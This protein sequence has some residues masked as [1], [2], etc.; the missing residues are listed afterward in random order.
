MQIKED[1]RWCSQRLEHACH[2]P[3][4]R[5]T[6]LT[7]VLA[8]IYFSLNSLF[9]FTNDDVAFIPPPFSAVSYIHPQRYIGRASLLLF[10]FA[11]VAGVS[12]T[13]CVHPLDV[14]RVN[15]Q[16]DAGKYRNALVRRSM[17]DFILVLAHAQPRV[18]SVLFTLK[19]IS[20]P[21][22]L[23][24]WLTALLVC[25]QHCVTDIAKTSGVQRGLYAGISAGIFRQ[26]VYGMPRMAFYSILL[27]KYKVPGETMPFYKKLALGLTAGGTASFIGTPS[28]VCLV[29]MSADGLK[30][31]HLRRNYKHVLDAVL[32][33][34][35]EE[36]IAALW[37]GAGPTVARACLL[38]AGQLGVY[39]EA[40]QT[41][42]SSAG[43][44]GIPLM[45]CSSIVA[46]FAAVGLSCPADVLKS[47]IQNSAPGE[48]KGLLDCA[49]QM[50]KS[51][52]ALS[53]WKGAGPAWIKLTPHTIISFIVLEKITM[54][55]SGEAAM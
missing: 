9:L 14:V 39:S 23:L 30:P 48:F 21:Y 3:C 27:E 36:G 26:V 7:A 37:K 17:D 46:G 29:R 33:I 42:E 34:G 45:F 52:G 25:P 4:K 11:G 43:L 47:R 35:K 31:E 40:K 10:S 1:V 53:L 6:G 2:T 13:L 15:M 19:A 54:W 5:L 28:E 18:I 12:A 49:S 8:L 38:N 44:T 16:V 55:Y 41:I 24:F 20:V 50:V 22:L 51:E 32:T